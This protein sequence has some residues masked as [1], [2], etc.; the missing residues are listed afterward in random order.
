MI[1]KTWLAPILLILF[2]AP[3]TSPAQSVSG[4]GLPFIESVGPDVMDSIQPDSASVLR[5][6]G[7][8]AGWSARSKGV[9]FHM[10]AIEADLGGLTSVTQ[11]YD[12]KGLWLEASHHLLSGRGLGLLMSGGFFFDVAGGADETYE[13]AGIIEEAWDT[14][15][16]QY[17]LDGAFTRFIGGRMDFLGGF[18]WDHLSTRLKNRE[19]GPSG[20]E[21]DV[22]VNC[23]IPYVG[24]QHR[25]SSTTGSMIL[26]VIGFPVVPGEFNYIENLGAGS[27]L[28]A[29]GDYHKGYFFETFFEF[30]RVLLGFADLGVY[31]KWSQ[32][33]TDSNIELGATGID[34]ET[35]RLILR[36]T[37]WTAGCR[38]SIAF[39]SPL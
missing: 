36:Q 8:Y 4:P 6:P 28:A 14:H 18:R 30:S 13:A 7:I 21:A 29:S 38:L 27:N 39:G 12:R 25:Y 3:H 35:F 5:M 34:P 33:S 16:E 20:T 32:I 26:R 15:T 10:E 37:F 17:Y 19:I 22:T 11:S 9:Q 2:L 24:L 31:G 1:R 23:Y